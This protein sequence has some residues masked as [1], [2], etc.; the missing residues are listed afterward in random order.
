MVPGDG[1]NLLT[2]KSDCKARWSDFSWRDGFLLE[3]AVALTIAIWFWRHWVVNWWDSIVE[4]T[5][6]IYNTGDNE[7]LVRGLFIEIDALQ[8]AILCGVNDRTLS[9]MPQR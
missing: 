6:E 4:M 3:A 8:S 2:G 5:D 9:K 1:F 7:D